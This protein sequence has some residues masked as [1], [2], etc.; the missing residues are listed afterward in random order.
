M[1]FLLYIALDT[2]LLSI[3]RVDGIAHQISPPI[4]LNFSMNAAIF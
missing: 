1:A 2:P 3:P 4:P